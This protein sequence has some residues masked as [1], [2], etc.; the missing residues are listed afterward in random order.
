MPFLLFQ[1][2]I[3]H[4]KADAI[5]N[6][7]NGA[8]LQGGGVCGAIFKGAGEKDMQQACT[9]LAPVQTGDAVM[10]PAFKLPSKYVIHAVGPRWAG[11]N[12][13]EELLLASC[14][15]K[16]L[17]LAHEKGLQSIA[18]P[19]ISAGIYGYPKYQAYK[20]AVSTMLSF[21]EEHELTI[22]LVLFE[23]GFFEEVQ[24]SKK[25]LADYV[26]NNLTE[27]EPTLDMLFST[28]ACRSCMDKPLDGIINEVALS[29]SQSLMALIREKGLD[30]VAVYKG[31]NIDRKHFS[32]IRSNASYQPN[33]RTVIALALSL[34]LNAKETCTLLETAGYSLSHSYIF[35]I[36]IEYFIEEKQ[37]DLY[38]INEALF[39]YDQPLL[40]A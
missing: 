5:V 37:Y 15:Q 31:A 14:Y 29:F 25:P 6:A 12:K 4:I 8:L 3:T 26:R 1:G 16:A 28:S 36:I 21:L 11:G 39:S 2:D 19:L 22:Y 9:S 38:A 35:D 33:K 40:G 23:K 20:I 24:P 18:F 27:T 10:T 13:N 7:A 17:L 30:E 32:K 34:K